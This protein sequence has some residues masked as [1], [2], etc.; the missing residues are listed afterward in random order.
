VKLTDNNQPCLT[1]SVFKVVLQE[2]MPTPI[3]Q[4]VFVLATVDDKLTDLWGG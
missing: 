1:Q 2:S 3:C 4:R